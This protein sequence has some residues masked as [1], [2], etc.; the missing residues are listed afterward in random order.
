MYLRWTKARNI[1]FRASSGLGYTEQGRD[2]PPI[3]LVP[4]LLALLAPPLSSVLDDLLVAPVRRAGRVAHILRL[5]KDGRSLN[6]EPVG[7]VVHANV[8]VLDLPDRL[9]RVGLESSG[10]GSARSAADV[11]VRLERGG[12]AGRVEP[13]SERVGL[14]NIGADGHRARAEHGQRSASKVS[15]LDA[16]ERNDGLV[17]VRVVL[18][19]LSPQRQTDSELGSVDNRQLSLCDLQRVQNEKELVSHPVRP[20]IGEERRKEE[21]HGSL[22]GLAGDGRDLRHLFDNSEH[23]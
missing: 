8:L 6:G 9:V 11:G 3:R 13:A 22:T 18:G 15:N 19:R 21:T 16:L 7:R 2:S 4:V 12:A 23:I 10:A 1:S 5:D 17:R 14:G 20:E